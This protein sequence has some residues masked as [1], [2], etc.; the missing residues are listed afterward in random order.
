[1]FADFAAVPDNV[2]LLTSREDEGTLGR[3]LFDRWNDRQR[4]D[5]KWD[6]GKIGNNIMLEGTLDMKVRKSDFGS[7]SKT[8]PDAQQSTAARR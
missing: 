5:D 6:K 7:I 8:F 1:M 3:L 2:V 4:G